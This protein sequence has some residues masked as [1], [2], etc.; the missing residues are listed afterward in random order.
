LVKTFG[1]KK[2]NLLAKRNRKQP[3]GEASWVVGAG[4]LVTAGELNE[5]I[6]T[7]TQ[8]KKKKNWESHFGGGG[9]EGGGK[10]GM[11]N[12]LPSLSTACKEKATSSST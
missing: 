1:N 5:I 3:R 7:R 4:I 2:T 9:E 11:K 12:F 8:I 10:K 6:Y